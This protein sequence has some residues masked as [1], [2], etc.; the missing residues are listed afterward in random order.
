MDNSASQPAFE[1]KDFS[2]FVEVSRVQQGWLVIWG[3][4]HDLGSRREHLGNRTYADLRGAR[5][6]VAEAALELTRDPALASDA[7][8]LFDR[9]P[10]LWGGGA[11][12]VL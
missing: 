10:R 8:L 11:S 12:G 5:R 9:S 7:V 3:R 6:R 4:Y 2:R 1:W